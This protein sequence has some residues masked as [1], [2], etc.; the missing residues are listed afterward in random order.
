MISTVP[1][2]IFPYVLW[3]L[4]FATIILFILQNLILLLGLG[5]HDI[6]FDH[7]T[8]INFDHAQSDTGHS[9][10]WFSFKNLVNFLLVFSITGLMFDS[11]KFPQGYTLF[12]STACGIIFSASMVLLMNLLYRL[13]HDPTPHFNELLGRPGACYLKIPQGGKGKIKIYFG[14]SIKILDAYSDETIETNDLIQVD[15]INGNDI[16]VVKQKSH[17]S[18]S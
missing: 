13:R 12:L 3:I 1:T 11:Y 7:D 6:S 14:G 10:N 9:F 16:F 15:R 4:S 5:H 18:N 8:D 2:S 17:P